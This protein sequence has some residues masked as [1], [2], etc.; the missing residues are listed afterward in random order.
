MKNYIYKILCAVTILLVALNAKA[1]DRNV[2]WVHGYGDNANFWQHYDNL[3]ENERKIDGLNNSYSNITNGVTNAAN[4]VKNSMN[5]LPNGGPTSSNNIGIGHSLGGLMIRDVDRSS[6]NFG[7]LITVAAPNY[8]APAIT[9][10]KNGDVQNAADNAINKLADGPLS[11][12]LIAP[13]Q[14]LPGLTT[15][16]IVNSL[17]GD[18]KFL[19]NN[20]TINEMEEGSNYINTLNNYNTTTPTITITAEENSPVH[21]NIIKSTGQYSNVVN[22]INTVRSLYNNRMHYNQTQAVINSFWNPFLAAQYSYKANA[23][24][25]GR[26]WIDDSEGIYSSLIKT[27]RTELETYYLSQWVSCDYP[28]QQLRPVETKN[29]GTILKGDRSDC[30]YWEYIPHTRYVSV[31]YPSDGLLPLYSQKLDGIPSGNKYHIIGANH[32]EVGDMSSSSQGDLTR[33]QFNLI[34][35]RN[36]FF[37]TQTRN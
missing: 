2:V 27:T 22:N 20:Q 31:N 36:D 25:K 35:N 17:F 16:D 6:S 28:P 33:A 11:E 12:L 37:G 24:K 4:K 5:N 32:L 18:F 10:V 21:W 13:W 23:W 9:S 1:Q 8:G 3:F 14:I 19:D 34:F 29:S 7:G 15:A 30:D 26:D